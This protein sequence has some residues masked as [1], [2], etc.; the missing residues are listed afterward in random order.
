MI[1][2]LTKLIALLLLT[3]ACSFSGSNTED[4]TSRPSDELEF[5]VDTL[6]E[7]T[8]SSL[9]VEEQKIIVENVPDEMRP[10]EETVLA[11][12]EP[13]IEKMPE[14][15][16][17]EDFK[18]EAIKPVITESFN[19]EPSNL[20]LGAE[21]KYHVQKGDTL[22]MVAFKIYGDYRKWKELKTWNK[23]RLV[24]KMGPGTVLKYYVPDQAFGWRPSGLPYMVKT[25]DNLGG[26][27][28]EKYGT[29]KKWRN[30]Y[31]NNRP[32]I[33]DPNLIF[34]GFTI[35]YVPVRDVASKTR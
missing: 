31:E 11:T 6:E 2:N 30:I 35:Y 19:H 23:D 33:R 1:K 16:K 25:G 4:I 10:I 32:L 15:P 20:A 24:T 17:F 8:P 14:E 28:M 27:S 34:A 18:Q 21:E 3:S 5:A 13:Q 22:M 9:A 7:S 26:I 29:S 12:N